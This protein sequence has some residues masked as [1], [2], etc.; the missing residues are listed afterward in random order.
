[1]FVTQKSQEETI[2]TLSISLNATTETMQVKKLNG[3]RRYNSHTGLFDYKYK[4][5]YN[6]AEFCF[7]IPLLH[8]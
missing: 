1:M 4:A 8:T 3:F 2:K 7:I 5:I 6:S